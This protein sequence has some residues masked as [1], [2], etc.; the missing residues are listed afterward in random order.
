MVV[1]AL[2]AHSVVV[3]WVK[4]ILCKICALTGRLRSRLFAL[5]VP[6]IQ[7]ALQHKKRL[8]FSNV[9]QEPSPHLSIPTFCLSTTLVRKSAMARRLPI[10]SCHFAQRDL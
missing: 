6:P 7:T 8:A 2:Y 10:W 5:K 9:R 4:F 1:T 3:V